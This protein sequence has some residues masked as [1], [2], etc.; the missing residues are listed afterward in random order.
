MKQ[1]KQRTTVWINDNKMNYFKF[2]WQEGYACFSI[3]KSQLGK[4][5]RYI[6][7]QEIHHKEKSFKE[8]Y[9]DFLEAY[10]IEYDKKYIFKEVK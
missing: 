1:V 4:V 3:S 10:G 7:E 6:Q 5:I 2:S 8:E 9:I